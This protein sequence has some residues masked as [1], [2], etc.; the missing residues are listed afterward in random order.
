MHQRS[1]EMEVDYIQEGEKEK[2]GKEAD[3]RSSEEDKR[4]SPDR[5][6]FMR[7][8]KLWGVKSS[9]WSQGGRRIVKR[10]KIKINEK[11]EGYPPLPSHGA[12]EGASLTLRHNASPGPIRVRW[13]RRGG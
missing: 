2:R 11:K 6:A 8:K 1:R 4:I 9:P 3:G 12:W 13:N 7:M 5:G 10:Q